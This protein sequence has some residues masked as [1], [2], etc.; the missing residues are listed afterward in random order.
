MSE[1]IQLSSALHQLTD[2]KKLI[3][4]LHSRYVSAAKT[5]GWH[6]SIWNGQINAEYIHVE[7]EEFYE[8]IKKYHPELIPKLP[9][10]HQRI[11]T[12]YTGT[13]TACSMLGIY[14]EPQPPETTEQAK[15][16]VSELMAE[17]RRLEHELAQKQGLINSLKPAADRYHEICLK[18]QE[19]ASK[20]R[21]IDPK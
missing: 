19:S 2:C 14:N 11:F 7:A 16:I 1:F 15:I 20:K 10:E 3:K 9:P 18:N 17:I 13:F 8:W 6:C 21:Q 4:S 12:T 5:H